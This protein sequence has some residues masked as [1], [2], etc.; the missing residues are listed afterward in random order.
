MVVALTVVALGTS[1]PEMVVAIQAA[2]TGYPGLL[3]GNVVG[4]NIAN[5]LLVGGLAAAVYPLTCS[6]PAVRRD[7]TLMV[8]ASVLFVVLCLLG[9]LNRGTGAGLLVALAVVLSFTARD[10][11][12]AH[13]DPGSKIPLDWALGLPTRLGYIIAFIAVGLVF[14]PMGA[15]LVVTASVEIAERIGV[16]E[17]VVGLSIIAFS[18]SLPE[19]ATTV[20]AAFQRRTEMVVGTIVGSNIFNLL[21]IIGIAALVSPSAIPVPSSFP[22]FDLPVMLIAA[23]ALTASV[24]LR[25]HIGRVLGGILAV[26]YAAY[27]VALFAGS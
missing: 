22:A 23:T 12:R 5:V 10:A 8:I 15:D 6:D 9:E 25:G 7:S 26:G 14:L 19:L 2:L 21:A 24:W 16:T 3:L 1:L 17:A 27:V 20:V 13:R 18:T 4:S 11:A